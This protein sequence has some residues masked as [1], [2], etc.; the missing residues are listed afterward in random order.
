[1]KNLDDRKPTRMPVRGVIN[2]GSLAYKYLLNYDREL[3]EKPK[4][5]D[6]NDF[7]SN[8]LNL[9]VI[10]ATMSHPIVEA[11]IIYSIGDFI[12]YESKEIDP[13]EADYSGEI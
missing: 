5:I 11:F 2:S 9:S 1:M 3:L 12:D 13:G 4:P 10:D 7:I 6:I 8:Y